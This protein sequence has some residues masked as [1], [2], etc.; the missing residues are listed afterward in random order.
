MTKRP[1][2]ILHGA[3]GSR[4]VVALKGNREYR[5]TLDGYDHPHLNLVLKQAEELEAGEQVATHDAV[6]VRGDNIV[7]VL[8]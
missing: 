2:D 4:I 1:L 7:Y 6:V 5:G 8:P 3:I